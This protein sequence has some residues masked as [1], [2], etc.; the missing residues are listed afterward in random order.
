VTREEY[1]FG[2]TAYTPP[3]FP[4]PVELLGSV[5][6][7]TNL[8]GGP[9]PLIVFLHGRHV[10]C[11]Q[12]GSAFLEWPCAAGHTPVPSYQGY[13][14]V[15]SALASH[16][17][18]LVSISANGINARDNSVSDLGALARAELIQKHLDLWNTFTTTGGAPFGTSFVGKVDMTNIG[19]MGHSRGGEGVVRE[20]LYNQS[21]GSPYGINAVL[22]LAPVDFNRPA[23][24]GVPEATILPY[25]DG[26]VSDLQGVHFYD[27]VRYNVAGDPAPKET[28][29][30]MGANHNY[31]NTI[32]TPGIGPAGAADDWTAFVG[33]GAGDPECGTVPTNHRLTPAQERGVGQ[34]Y[35]SAFFRVYIGKETQFTPFLRGDLLPPPTAMNAQVHVSYQAPDSSTSRMDVNRQLA[36][37]NLATNTLGGSVVTSGL[38][39]YDVYGGDPPETRYV[40]PG[41][42]GTFG[43]RYPHTTPSARDPNHRGLSQL[44]LAFNVGSVNPSYENDL[45][46]GSQDVSGFYA[47]QF[48][49][50]V[51]WTDPRNPVGQAQDFTVTLSDGVNTASTL[52]STWSTALYY[53]PGTVNPVPK[54]F[55]NTVRIPL[56]AFAS[57]GVDLTNVQS[58]VL[59]FDQTP[60]GSFLISDLAFVDPA[61]VYAGPFVVS[62]SPTGT[63]SGPIDH[64]RVFFNT[65]IDASSFDP[66]QV[67]FTGPGGAIPVTVAA[68]PGT[69]NSEFDVSFDPQSASGAY[70]VVIG[71]NVQDTHSHAMDQN[72]N[73][74]TGEVP[75]DQYTATFT[76]A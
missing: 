28:F 44:R 66:T 40:F 74:V 4:G 53:P 14:Y 76:I 52:V 32:W 15:A 1:D 48:R 46:A 20:Y 63:V 43:G 30:V 17:Y 6:H 42:G 67:A 41:E 2:N 26:D 27:D 39:V 72:F 10:T 37:A 68:V 13:D 18:F 59:N 75:C 22:P 24:N 19:I 31:F 33:G 8:S 47:L 51:N 57:Q 11:Y 45:P 12:G 34:A 73:G 61:T 69:N 29:L 38:S 55:L 58:V 49:A 50:S 5:H 25:C 3:G 65:V 71:P 62:T 64:V 16:G 7:P 9:F 70:T 23:N 36:P 54:I 56:D 60:S 21:L 35:L